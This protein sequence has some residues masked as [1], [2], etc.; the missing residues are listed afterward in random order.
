MPQDDPDAPPPSQHGRRWI[1]AAAVLWSSSPLFV[2]SAMFD[3]WPA[4]DRGVRLAFWRALFAGLLLIPAVRRPRLRPLMALMVLCFAGVNICYLSAMTL[5][6]AAN[7]IWLQNTAPLW[8]M[9]FGAY[10]LR[11]PFTRKQAVSALFLVAGLLVIIIPG[12]R[13]EQPASVLLGLA[14]GVFYAAVVVT[15]RALRNEDGAW[16]VVL[17]H[18]GAAIIIAP[19]LV[20]G[21]F[22]APSP[23]QLVTLALFGFIQMGLAYYCFSRGLR[24]VGGSEAALIALL[25]PLL[26]P[27]WAYAISGERPSAATA[28]GACA[29]LCGLAYEVLARSTVHRR[30]KNG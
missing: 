15:L 19:F 25:E 28:V 14:S 5:G 12:L 30:S 4:D 8:V 2:K 7:A 24:S 6:T 29:I 3:D 10:A 23:A 20:S 17:N 27:V 1:V 16:L 26:V 13:N 18:L 11:E 21:T 9:L 22:V